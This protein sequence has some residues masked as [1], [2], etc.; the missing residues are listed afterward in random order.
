MTQTARE[1]AAE[2][3]S[4]NEK[5]NSIPTE[6]RQLHITE[7]TKKRVTQIRNTFKNKLAKTQQ[8][9]DKFIAHY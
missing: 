5:I 8:E 3:F 6:H 4:Q 1:W 9:I 2:I 7:E